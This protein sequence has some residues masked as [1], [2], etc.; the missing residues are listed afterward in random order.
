MYKRSGLVLIFFSA[1]LQWR[2]CGRF[3]TS[4][5][6][7]SINK[8]LKE[9]VNQEWPLKSS[10][11]SRKKPF[12]RSFPVCFPD[13]IAKRCRCKCPASSPGRGSTSP[14][15][16]QSSHSRSSEVS[17]TIGFGGTQDKSTTPSPKNLLSLLAYVSFCSSFLPVFAFYPQCFSGMFLAPQTLSSV[18]TPGLCLWAQSPCWPGLLC[19]GRLL[20]THLPAWIKLCHQSIFIHL[21]LVLS[22]L[23][24][25][26]SKPGSLG[27]DSQQH[28]AV[29]EWGTGVSLLNQSLSHC[30]FC[31]N[32]V[33]LI[34]FFL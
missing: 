25:D 21:P 14:C 6:P 27:P 12:T 24:A 26:S 1:A 9:Q 20:K 31:L 16:G 4:T 2:W 30:S 7:N 17:F 19:L 3:L 22:Q 23:S 33:T 8:S 10:F 29:F 5:G 11:C 18:W 34:Y 28:S 13:T 15:C 32:Y